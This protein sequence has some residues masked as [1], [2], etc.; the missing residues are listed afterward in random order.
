MGRQ[1]SVAAPHNYPPYILDILPA[2]VGQPLLN[3]ARM[4]K[5]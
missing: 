3:V 2:R 1:D 5:F 4:I